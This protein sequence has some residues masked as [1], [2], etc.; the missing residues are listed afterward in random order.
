MRRGEEA[1]RLAKEKEI[2]N[3]EDRLSKE[4]EVAS[5]TRAIEALEK[6]YKG[7][8]SYKDYRMGKFKPELVW[9]CEGK[10]NDEDKAAYKNEVIK[11]LKQY[12]KEY[13]LINSPAIA[14]LIYVNRL[15]KRKELK[16]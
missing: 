2:W 8:Y 15:N 3:K 9:R 10:Y 13:I 6:I 7:F 16:L 12:K 14:N 11:I 1:E 5:W 4:E